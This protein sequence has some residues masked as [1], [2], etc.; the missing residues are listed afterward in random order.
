MGLVTNNFLFSIPD[1]AP[2]AA[3]LPGMAARF[4]G[5]QLRLPATFTKV[6]ESSHLRKAKSLRWIASIVALLIFIFATTPTFAQSGMFY[7]LLRAR[8]LT[9]FGFVRLD[10]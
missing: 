3:F 10:M 9:P 7:G 2:R 8:D 1:C 6:K 5:R 4:P